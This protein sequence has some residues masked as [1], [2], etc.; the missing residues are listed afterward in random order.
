MV[1]TIRAFADLIICNR[2]SDLEVCDTPLV[3]VRPIKSSLYFRKRNKFRRSEDC[4]SEIWIDLEKWLVKWHDTTYEK[5]RLVGV[6]P[7]PIVVPPIDKVY[8]GKRRRFR[9]FKWRSRHYSWL[10]QKIRDRSLYRSMCSPSGRVK[11]DCLQELKQFHR[12]WDFL[13]HKRRLSS[14]LQIIMRVQQ[15]RDFTDHNDRFDDCLEELRF[16]SAINREYA[17]Y[18]DTGDFDHEYLVEYCYSDYFIDHLPGF[19]FDRYF[20]LCMAIEFDLGADDYDDAE[21][22]HSDYDS[23]SFRSFSSNQ[24]TL[25]PGYLSE[26]HSSDRTLSPHVDSNGFWEYQSGEVDINEKD[27]R[28]RKFKVKNRSRKVDHLVGEIKERKLTKGEIKKLVDSLAKMEANSGETEFTQPPIVVEANDNINWTGLFSEADTLGSVENIS[29]KTLQQY[30]GGTPEVYR[31]F[32]EILRVSTGIAISVNRTQVIHHVMFSAAN[33]GIDHF[34][35]LIEITNKLF[36]EQQSLSDFSEVLKKTLDGWLEGSFLNDIKKCILVLLSLGLSSIPAFSGLTSTISGFFGDPKLLSLSGFDI[37]SYAL[38]AFLYMYKRIELAIKERSFSALFSKTPDLHQISQ[39]YD[40]LVAIYPHT[41]AGD[42][43]IGGVTFTPEQFTDRVVTLHQQLVR[44]SK[45]CSA[46]H[47]VGV[48]RMKHV[49]CKIMLDCEMTL[50]AKSIRAKPMSINLAGTSGVGKTILIPVFAK[51]MASAYDIAL[52]QDMVYHRSPSDPYWSGYAGHPVLVEDEKNAVIATSSETNENKTTLDVVNNAIMPLNMA[53]LPSKGVFFMRSKVHIMTTNKLDAQASLNCN[54]PAAVLRR[55]LHIIVEVK[56]EFKKD[57]SDMIDPAKCSFDPIRDDAWLF[58]FMTCETVPSQ[59]LANC[60]GYVWDVCVNQQGAPMNKVTLHD[61]LV[62]LRYRTEEHIRQEKLLL[63]NFKNLYDSELCPH[64]SGPDICRL[65]KPELPKYPY[66]P[67]IMQ[68]GAVVKNHEYVASYQDQAGWLV[69]G[70]WWAFGSMTYHYTHTLIKKHYWLSLAFSYMRL[71]FVQTFM[72]ILGKIPSFGQDSWDSAL[73]SGIKFVSASIRDPRM[74]DYGVQAGWDS[75]PKLFILTCIGYYSFFPLIVFK[76]AGLGYISSFVIGDGVAAGVNRVAHEYYRTFD[77][78][79]AE[80][81]F[82]LWASE[83]LKPYLT[84]P[85][86]YTAISAAVTSFLIVYQLTRKKP[87]EQGGAISSDW[88]RPYVPEEKVSRE[89]NT[90]TSSDLIQSIQRRI[91][92]ARVYTMGSTKCSPINVFPICS[93]IWG[94]PSHAFKN[95]STGEMLKHT[96]MDFV[97]NDALLGAN[98]KAVPID[99]ETMYFVP[100][101]DMVMLYVPQTAGHMKDFRPYFTDKHEEC[102]ATYVYKDSNGKLTT[103][104][105]NSTRMIVTRSD[106]PL[107]EIVYS[108]ECP[109]NTFKGLCG[110]VQVSNT[111]NP[112][113]VSFHIAGVPDG[114]S[115]FCLPILRT[116][117]DFGISWIMADRM[118]IQ[119]ASFD[120]LDLTDGDPTKVILDEPHNKSPLNFLDSGSCMYFG[121]LPSRA[122][123]SGT[124]INTIMADEVSDIFGK[125]NIYGNPQC[126]RSWKVWHETFLNVTT[127]VFKDP[128]LL[129]KAVEDYHGPILESLLKKDLSHIKPY[130]IRTAVSGIDGNEFVK[131]VDIHTSTGY[132]LR[133]KKS[134]HL[135]ISYHPDDPVKKW[136]FDLDDVI[137]GRV[138]KLEER[139]AKGERGDCIYSAGLK[140][141][142]KKILEEID[143]E[144][145]PK[146]AFPRVFYG[147]PFELIILMRQYF[148]PVLELVQDCDLSCMSIGINAMGPDWSDLAYRL[149]KRSNDIMPADQMKYD[150]SV[151]PEEQ[152]PHYRFLISVAERCSY[153]NKDIHMM[154]MLAGMAIFAIIEMNADFVS[155]YTLLLSGGFGTAQ[156]NSMVNAV[157]YIMAFYSP[158]WRY[159]FKSTDPKGY[160]EHVEG[161]NFR[162]CVTAEFFG[163]D[164]I[165]AVKSELAPYFNLI[166]FSKF[167]ATQG[168]T[169]T[170]AMKGKVTV[171]TI[172]LEKCD[173]LK[174]GFRFDEERGV[175]AAP[176]CEDSIFKRLFVLEP[177]KFLTHREQCGEAISSSLRDYFQYGRETFNDRRLKLMELARRCNLMNYVSGGFP[178]YDFFVQEYKSKYKEAQIP[179]P[180]GM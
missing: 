124:I 49:I 151:T 31:L 143:G 101:M 171:G 71:L 53:D 62:F 3:I 83:N 180:C 128:V 135:N 5:V 122:K 45:T 93:G 42:V 123:P 61:A 74:R 9:N 67:S 156:V 140:I 28:R 125:K 177:S 13:H 7:P 172:P 35:K 119:T 11:I 121:S 54:E 39:E 63:S 33:L 163:D 99:Y 75:M 47:T 21:G 15:F 14:S 131:H 90:S 36:F 41:K 152:I 40:I 88:A 118:T 145:Q 19:I 68:M 132:P 96:H 82:K 110:A 18:V 160:K 89:R 94:G 176:L 12:T 137:L 126:I 111:K 59:N 120:R 4:F 87:Q 114:K 92:Y 150:Q 50:G 113:I 146:K 136:H 64:N 129:R 38:K 46:Q 174:R 16:V 158:E 154:H 153:S 27:H 69:L 32:V 37:L 178:E 29:M 102:C 98:L 142:A 56:K 115:S 79:G 164:S 166:S 104:G 77:R 109:F 57:G 44:L 165:P 103:S 138:K 167:M 34:P 112:S 26:S 139:L 134:E 170:D 8:S 162:D 72:T 127:P 84:S 80:S 169:V 58:T 10:Q 107:A 30:F 97:F 66:D 51:V 43:D 168:V 161:K 52:T 76:L 81:T 70:L 105:D 108:C 100:D 117:I 147:A 149:R 141:E 130:D 95:A 173:Y 179:Q 116:H 148:M 48:N 60:S 106:R 17:I 78:R 175:V 159:E 155:F 144:F 86:T 6:R 133:D 65:C 73:I 25:D 23:M 24:S 91:A 157:R 20:R 85:Y 22:V 1:P 2:Y 55:S